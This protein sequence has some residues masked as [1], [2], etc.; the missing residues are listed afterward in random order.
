LISDFRQLP[1]P[2]GDSPAN[3]FTAIP[4]P[5]YPSHRLGKDSHG[6]P[7]F[8]VSAQRDMPPGPPISL[9]HLSVQYD[10][11]CLLT[12]VGGQ[13][14]RR[15]FSVLRCIEGD[16]ALD[17]YFIRVGSTIVALLGDNP[18]QEE[19]QSAM[20]RLVDL[21]RA[22][23]VPPRHS[24][25]GLWGELFLVSR[26]RNLRLALQAWH[27]FPEDRYDFSHVNQRLEVKTTATQERTHHF[28]LG[29]LV[30]VAGVTIVIASMFVQR[31]G[32]GTS[33][34]ELVND[35]RNRIADDLNLLARIDQ[36]V[37]FTLGDGWRTASE[38]R[39]DLHVAQT[40]LAFYEASSVPKPDP[41]VPP[42][43]TDVHFRSNL[44]TASPISPA[45]LRELGGLF[46]AVAP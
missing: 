43:V 34:T 23:D 25:Q 10:A 22:L 44:S 31:A 20:Q 30:P 38:D 29:Q 16:S 32:N 8:L 39:F 9:Q 28:S 42:E 13:T 45:S 7:S 21:F 12:E 33:V 1:T 19:L 24:I 5:G 2:T 18:T 36:L 40:S 17:E 4:L 15:R 41:I 27:A 6:Y 14:S 26:A 35:F 46:A 37:S 3:R 11:D